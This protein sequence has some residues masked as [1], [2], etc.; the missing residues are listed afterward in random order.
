MI[1]PLQI[2]VSSKLCMRREHIQG[3]VEQPTFATLDIRDQHDLTPNLELENGRCFAVLVQEFDGSF[4]GVHR[5][6]GLVSVR[7]NQ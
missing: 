4:I 3:S 1:L 7:T 5:S 2:T 6:L